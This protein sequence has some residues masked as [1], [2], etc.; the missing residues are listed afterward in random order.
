MTRATFSYGQRSM[1]MICGC[2]IFLTCHIEGVGRGKR[3]KYALEVFMVESDGHGLHSILTMESD[4]V[5]YYGYLKT[6]HSR[7]KI[8]SSSC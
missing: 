8:C 3:I 4:Y 6:Q 5:S 1:H 2:P 7:S